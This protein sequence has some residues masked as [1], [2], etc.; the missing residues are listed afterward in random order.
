MASWIFQGNPDRFDVDGYL[1]GYDTVYWS[2]T[3]KSYQSLVA[4]RDIVYVGGL[5]A[6]KEGKQE[7]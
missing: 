3:R 4:L 2:V 7:S 6:G 5:L 1:S